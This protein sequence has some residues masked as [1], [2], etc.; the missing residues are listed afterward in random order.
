MKRILIVLL[1]VGL[2]GIAGIIA[3]SSS[4]AELREMVSHSAGDVRENI[5]QKY[6][7]APGATV[8]LMGLNGPV[9]IE[10]SDGQTAEVAIERV[11]SS[12]EALDRRRVNIESTPSNLRIRAER[13]NTGFF[14][15]LFGSEAG[16]KVTLKLP[17]QVSLLAKG[18]NGAVTVGEMNGSVEMAGINGRIQVARA[19]GTATFKGINGN[20]VVALSRLDQ[21]GIRLSGINGNINLQLPEDANAD[22]EAR[23]MNGRVVSDLPNVTIDKTSKHGNYSARIGT[24]GTAIDA[25]GINGNIRLSSF[26]GSPAPGIG[27]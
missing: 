24:G 20:I 14:G 6:E 17:R 8:E 11:G 1:L 7:L 3:R 25:K 21:E 5:H 4:R 16:E 22:L 23:G 18:I 19:T 13:V 27:N 15:R 9:N 10:T 26:S 12:Q 2:A